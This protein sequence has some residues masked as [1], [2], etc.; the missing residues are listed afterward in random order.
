MMQ[1]TIESIMNTVDKKKVHSH[2]KSVALKD[3]EGYEKE[4]LKVLSRILQA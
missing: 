1:A 3:N 2:C 4:S